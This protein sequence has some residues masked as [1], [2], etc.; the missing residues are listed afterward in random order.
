MPDCDFLL[1]LRL[2]QLNRDLAYRQT[3]CMSLFEQMLQK[4]LR[5]F[6]TFTDHTLLHS[7]SVTNLANQML[8]REVEKLNAEEIYI[9]LMAAALHDVGMAVSDRDFEQFLR[10]Q[11]QGKYSG[12]YSEAEKMDLIR[13]L[14]NEFSAA[15]VKKYWEIFDIPGE[16]YAA[17]I[18][19]VCRGH[20][21]TDLFNEDE[22][23]VDYDLED[24]GKRVNLA[25]LAAVVRLA[26]ELDVASDRNPEL[27]YVEGTKGGTNAE[28]I[29]EFAKHDAIRTV[30]FTRD[31]V[32]IA[33][34][35]GDAGIAEAVEEVVEKIRETLSYCLSVVEN[36]SALRLGCRSV[37]LILNGREEER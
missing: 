18:A 36:R 7:L 25:L 32:L 37:H 33:A 31:T 15:F 20:R 12:E 34:D 6:P 1:E 28:S 14:H 35:T 10:A 8:G 21:K 4:I 24:G 9:L 2:K 29:R 13:S 3:C 16:R 22:Y 26:D 11:G 23:P 30:E 5:A 19:E 17:A 27:L